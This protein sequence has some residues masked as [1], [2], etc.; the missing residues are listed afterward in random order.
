M[1]ERITVMRNGG[2]FAEDDRNN[3][4][5]HL[6][7]VVAGTGGECPGSAED[8]PLFFLVDGAIR[9][10]KFGRLAGFHFNKDEGI[11]VA[12]DNVDFGIG[13]GPVVARDDGEAAAAEKAMRQIFAFAPERCIRLQDFPL[14]RLAHGIDQTP[15]ELP[16]F[17]K[18]AASLLFASRCH[19]MTL[20]RIR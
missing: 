15:D 10:A 16:R 20:P 6:A 19:S 18:P 12:S 17:G 4:E 2:R 5:A 13:A 1:E 3:I 14:F 11:A 8:V 7:P 9:A